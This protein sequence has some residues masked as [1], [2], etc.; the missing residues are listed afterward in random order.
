MEFNSRKFTKPLCFEIEQFLFGSLSTSV[1]C[2]RTVAA[3]NAMT[4][5]KY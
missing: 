5:N 4:R 1:A 3:D 2:Q